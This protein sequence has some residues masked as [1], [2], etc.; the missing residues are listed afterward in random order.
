[1]FKQQERTQGSFIDGIG[2]IGDKKWEIPRY[3][4]GVED[5]AGPGRKSLGPHIIPVQLF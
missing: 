4:F 5:F 3:A 2:I 1:V